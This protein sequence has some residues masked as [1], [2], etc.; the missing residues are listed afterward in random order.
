[1]FSIGQRVCSRNWATNLGNGLFP[2]G[3]WVPSCRCH[4]RVSV[5][6]DRGYVCWQSVQRNKHLG[7]L[8]LVPP[9]V[10]SNRLHHGIILV[11]LISSAYVKQYNF[12]FVSGILKQTCRVAGS[13]QE[14]NI[15]LYADMELSKRH[16]VSRR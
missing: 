1:M 7:I 4:W 14:A 2:P 12:F 3:R 6:G 5:R 15:L 10:N 13:H 9:I 16:R 11:R 8:W